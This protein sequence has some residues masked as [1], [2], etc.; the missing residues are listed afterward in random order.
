MEPL[1]VGAVPTAGGV[2]LLGDSVILGRGL[3]L[4]AAL[5]SR[6]MGWSRDPADRARAASSILLRSCDASKRGLGALTE[7]LDPKGDA[8]A[9]GGVT[10]GRTAGLRG[11]GDLAGA[12]GWTRLRAC[13]KSGRGGAVE[14]VLGRGTAGRRD[15]VERAAGGGDGWCDGSSFSGVWSPWLLGGL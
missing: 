7:R 11:A 13:E 12:D 1:P 6:W 5:A 10:L 14:R 15:R 3:A 4:G 2:W 9:A 8:T